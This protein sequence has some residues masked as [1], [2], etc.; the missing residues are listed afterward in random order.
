M[1]RYQ[2]TALVI[3]LALCLSLLAACGAQT[4]N[5][6]G[7]EPTP[8]QSQAPESTPPAAQPTESDKPED[9]VVEPEVKQD[10]LSYLWD[11]PEGTPVEE[12]IKLEL[13]NASLILAM[14]PIFEEES[15]NA[16]SKAATSLRSR[17]NEERLATLQAA[18]AA[19]VQTISVED[20]IYFIWNDF[21]S[22]P[23]ADGESYTEEEL[24]GASLLGYGYTTVLVKYL[25]DDPAAAKGNIIFVSG[26]AMKGRANDSEGYPAVKV[27]NELGYNCFLLQRRVEP[28]STMDIYMDCQRAVRVVRYY[29]EQEN[30]GGQDMIAACGWSG[31]GATILGAIRNCYGDM[32]PAEYDSDYVPDAIDAVSSD[33]DV[34]LIIYGAYNADGVGS[35]VGDN[36]NLPAFYINHGTGDT[37]IS[38]SFAQELYDLVSATVPAKLTFVEGAPHGYGVSGEEAG[39]PA[40]CSEWP[41]EADQF[42][43]G[44]RGHATK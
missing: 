30:W 31:G 15:Y 3:A 20:G 26:G 44:N 2:V 4:G 10:L 5:Q 27:F 38:V 24:D 14:E 40:A 19:L 8:T 16:Y 22:M 21:E 23:I 11:I 12:Q 18:K 33:L 34:A 28:Y 32:T 17:K 13:R 7:T 35:F 25:L 29:A 39:F 43:Q 1:K 37:T 9:P 42:M 36:P 41:T 6:P